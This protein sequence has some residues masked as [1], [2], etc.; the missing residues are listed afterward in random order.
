M[1]GKIDIK[2]ANALLERLK[3]AKVVNLDMPLGEVLS[4]TAE[5]KGLEDVGG[6]V[7]AW[8]KYVIVNK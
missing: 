8:D 5:Q 2:T 6:H 3:E 4:M 7:I 1:E